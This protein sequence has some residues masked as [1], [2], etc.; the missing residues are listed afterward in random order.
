MS[1]KILFKI[2][3]INAFILVSCL[4]IS[5][6]EADRKS[7]EFQ[8]LNTTTVEKKAKHGSYNFDN[9]E[10]LQLK[11]SLREIS[12]LS[13]HSLKD[14]IFT[15]NDEKGV[16]YQINIDTAAY[17]EEHQFGKDGDYEGIAIVGDTVVLAKSNGDLLFYYLKSKKLTSV[18]TELA[19]HNDVEGLCLY[20]DHNALLIACKGQLL[21][22]V[23]FKNK[24][25]AIYKFNLNSNKLDTRPFL[26]ITDDDLFQQLKKQNIGSSTSKKKHKKLEN[27]AKSFSPSGIA[28]H[29][30]TKKTFIVSA[31]GSTLVIVNVEKQI[32]KLIFLDQKQLNQ[33][34]GIC[35]DNKLNL[36][37]STES[38]GDMGR[39]YKFH[40]GL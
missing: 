24:S 18:E 7:T 27:R 5:C 22:E 39:I 33:P 17:E 34:E 31:K 30:K 8:Q 9:F 37:I 12:G 14:Q 13:Y 11:A 32:E 21:N 6:R 4:L 3:V 1:Y 38:K 20:L 16:I 10:V 19:K 28:I 15:H 23:D 29:P 40:A 25:K 26:E 36:Y 2:S 35:F